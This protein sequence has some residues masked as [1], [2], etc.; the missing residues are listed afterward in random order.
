[1]VPNTDTDKDQKGDTFIVAVIVTET[2]INMGIENLV[3][4]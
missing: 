3:T 2:G 1:M 4:Y